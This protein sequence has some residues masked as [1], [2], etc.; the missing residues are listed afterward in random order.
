MQ[1][2][3]EK[4]IGTEWV[5]DKWSCTN[6]F[7]T[8]VYDLSALN[9]RNQYIPMGGSVCL[10]STSR[11]VKPKTQNPKQSTEQLVAL[12]FNI[13]LV[14]TNASPKSCNVKE[15]YSVSTTKRG[16]ITENE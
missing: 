16:H 4:K 6:L 5:H 15:F 10:A 9:D 12:L 8:I 7:F 3:D 14:V 1:H 2:L 13:C 11:P